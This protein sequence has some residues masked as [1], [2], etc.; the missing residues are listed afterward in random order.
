MSE[1]KV[2]FCSKCKD[3][4]PYNKCYILNFRLLKL[5]L[6]ELCSMEVDTLLEDWFSDRA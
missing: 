4:H 6:C 2:S 1:L 3:P 5:E